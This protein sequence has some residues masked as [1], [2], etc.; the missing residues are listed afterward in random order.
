MKIKFSKKMKIV[1]YSVLFLMAFALGLYLECCDKKTFEIT[2]IPIPSETPAST[3]S[4]SSNYDE[5]GRLD[6]NTATVD[7][8]DA[9]DGI[10]PKTAQH[11]VEY[12]EANGEFRAIEELTLVKGI[13]EGMVNRLRPYICI[14]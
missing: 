9:I 1:L 10:G 8:L 7:E 2:T 13:G 6:I 5:D 12:R 3:Q 4:Y 14:R 11:I